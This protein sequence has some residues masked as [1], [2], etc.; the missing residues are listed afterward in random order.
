MTALARQLASADASAPPA[1]GQAR[2]SSPRAH[3]IASAALAVKIAAAVI[4]PLVAILAVLAGVASFA[5]I[6]HLA[7]PWFGATAWIVP[8][9][10][11]I[12]I[13]ILLAWDLLAEYLRF[14]WPALRWT[15]WMFIGGTIYLNIAA[16]H[17]NPIASVMHAAM[18]AIFVTAA[19]GIRHLIRQWTGLAAGT[20]IERVPATRW[21]LSPWSSFTLARRMILWQVTSYRRGLA[22]EYQRLQAIARLQETY[23]RRLWRWKAPLRD[24][25][26][27]RLAWAG[28]ATDTGTMKTPAVLDPPG[29]A[30]SASPDDSPGP[31]DAM[32][33]L[34][35]HLPRFC[36]I[37]PP[38]PMPQNDPNRLLIDTASEILRE[39][40]RHGQRITQATLARKLRERG[41][42]VAND[43]L[44]SIFAAASTGPRTHAVPCPPGG[45]DG[46]A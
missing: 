33:T 42:R 45:T 21:L 34:L 15:A 1:H 3:P 7:A 14:P 39:A 31:R 36:L 43:R 10:I 17:G 25:L 37:E 24:R 18:P 26:A 41:H 5:T 9:G 30:P 38:K 22:L 27:L 11:D 13:L 35:G 4:A 16:A 2:I 44:G 40:E 46:H 8:V 29:E 6:R 32:S 12:G 19:E 23:G 28:S 20:R